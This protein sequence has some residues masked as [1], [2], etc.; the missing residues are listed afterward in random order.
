MQAIRGHT[1]TLPIEYLRQGLPFH[2]TIGQRAFT[3][4]H[5]ILIY[6]FVVADQTATSTH[7]SG[8]CNIFFIF[9]LKK[10]FMLYNPFFNI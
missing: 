3:L 2:N 10:F 7:I 8:C 6:F 5:T 1:Y 9:T 4:I